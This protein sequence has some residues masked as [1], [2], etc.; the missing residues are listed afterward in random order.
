[1]LSKTV[2]S[3]QTEVDWR[4]SEADTSL[5][6]IGHAHLMLTL[7]KVYYTTATNSTRK[8]IAVYQYNNSG[9]SRNV[10]REVPKQL[11][12][13]KKKGHHFS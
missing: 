10:E 7:E 11:I 2:T 1:M 13:L 4:K 3:Q 12:L 5:Y 6:G 8:K 9:G